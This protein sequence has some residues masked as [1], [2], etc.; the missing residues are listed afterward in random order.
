[1]MQFTVSI[2][3]TMQEVPWFTFHSFC[4]VQGEVLSSITAYSITVQ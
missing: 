4:S 1:M 3:V 2:K